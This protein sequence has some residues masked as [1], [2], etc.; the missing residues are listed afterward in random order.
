M[1]Y[2][3]A[4]DVVLVFHV[5]FI[6]FVIAGG[7]L[8]IARPRL[9]WLHL[10]AVVWVALLEFN[11]WTCPLTPLEVMLRQGAGGA[12]YEGGF[13]DHYLVAAIY[14]AGLTRGIQVLLGA[15]VVALNLAAYAMVC[16][17]VLRRESR[18]A[19]A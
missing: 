13:I 12:G 7:A 15:A 10:P 9:A 8:V 5:L 11:G 6:A 19:Q 4:A 14:P 16:R 18:R 17:R 1:A 3:I 2:R